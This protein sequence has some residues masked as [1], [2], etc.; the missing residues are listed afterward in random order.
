MVWVSMKTKREWRSF[1]W[2]NYKCTHVHEDPATKIIIIHPPCLFLSSPQRVW[3]GWQR[4]LGFRFEGLVWNYVDCA[5]F[6]SR[7]LWGGWMEENL[8]ILKIPLTQ[9]YFGTKKNITEKIYWFINYIFGFSF[10]FVGVC[11]ATTTSPNIQ[12]HDSNLTVSVGSIPRFFV[13]EI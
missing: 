12:S 4:K 5:V 2:F 10:H 8:I 13:M 3:V 11:I 7:I 1:G 6:R 9:I